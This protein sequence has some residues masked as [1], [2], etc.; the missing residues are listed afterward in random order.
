MPL[1]GLGIDIWLLTPGTGGSR[2]PV[3][4]GTELLDAQLNQI[5][6]AQGD[7]LESAS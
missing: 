5:I 4:P 3:P 1:M 7:N 2:P 6:D